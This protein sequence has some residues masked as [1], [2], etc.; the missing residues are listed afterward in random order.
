MNAL[1]KSRD[2]S[3][4]P[5]LRT[6]I[7]RRRREEPHFKISGKRLNHT[8]LTS[9]CVSAAPYNERHN[10]TDFP[11]IPGYSRLFPAIPSYFDPLHKSELLKAKQITNKTDPKTT[12]PKKNLFPPPTDNRP[13]PTDNPKN[14]DKHPFQPRR[15]AMIEKYPPSYFRL[16]QPVEDISFFQSKTPGSQPWPQNVDSRSSQ[17]PCPGVSLQKLSQHQNVDLGTSHQIPQKVPVIPH[18]PLKKC[19]LPTSR[20]RQKVGCGNWDLA[21]GN[22]FVISAW[23]L[24]IPAVY[25]QKAKSSLCIPCALSVF[26]VKRASCPEPQPK[27]SKKPVSSPKFTFQHSAQSP[28]LSRSVVK[29]GQ[30]QNVDC[31]AIPPAPPGTLHLKKPVFAHFRGLW[32]SLSEQKVDSPFARFGHWSFRNSFVLRVWSLVI[33]AQILQLSSFGALAPTPPPDWKIELIAQ[34]PELRHPSVVCSAPDGRVF[35][36]EDPMDISTPRADSTE[37][38]ILCFFPDGHHTVFAEKLHAVFGIQYVEGKVYVLHNPQFSVFTDNNGIGKDRF[39]LIESMNPNPWALEWNDHVPANFKL[40]MDGY[41]YM[42]VGDKGVYGAVGRDGKRVDLP[43][44]GILRLRPDGTGLEVYCT[45]VRNILDVALTDEDEIFTYD[46][47]D[48]HEW[49]GR[50][51]HMV[52]GGFYGYPHDFIPRRPYTLWMMHDFGGGAACGTLAYT[53]DVLPSEYQNNLFLADF[54]KRQV[55]RVRIEREGGTFRVSGSED[56]FANPPNDFRP[57]GI[58]WSADGKGFY[59]CDWNH[60]DTKENVLVGRFWKATYTGQTRGT[61][62]PQW[63]L[64]AAMGKSFHA[65]SDELIEGLSHPSR[66]LRLAAQRALISR[67]AGD[68]AAKLISLRNSG[69]PGPALWHALW[70]L[71]ALD[72]PKAERAALILAHGSDRATRHQSIRMLGEQKSRAAVTPLLASLKDSD[73]SLRFQSATALGRIAD[74]NALPALLQALDEADLYARFAGFTA[75]NRIGRAEP[76]AWHAIIPGLADNNPRIREGTEF[77]IRET[78]DPSLVEALITMAANSTAALP[79]RSSA[80]RC[81]VSLAHR[82][83][84][85]RGEWGAY[86]PALAPAPAKTNVW[87]GTPH[88]FAAFEHALRDP[89]PPLRLLAIEGMRQADDKPSTARTLRAQFKSEHHPDVKAALISALGEFKDAQ[90]TSDL[91]EILNGERENQKIFEAAVE[92]ASRIGGP[93]LENSLLRLSADQNVPG[94]QRTLVIEALGELKSPRTVAVLKPLL[95]NDEHALRLAAQ[96]T[97]AKLGTSEAVAT[98]CSLLTS[99]SREIQR[100]T[101]AA[102]G[103][104]RNREAVPP[105]IKAW[106]TPETREAAISALTEFK[107]I[108]ALDAYIDGLASVDPNLRN[109]CRAALEAMREEA[110]PQIETRV[111]SLS[112]EA[113]KELRFVYRDSQAKA[114]SLFRDAAAPPSQQEYAAYA[115][116]HSGDPVRGQKIF[117]DQTGVACIKCHTVNGQGAPTGPDLTSI[118][119]QFPRADLIEHVLEPSKVVREGYQQWNIETRDGESYSGLIRAESAD[120]LTLI[121][122]DGRPQAIP[123][124]SILSRTASRISLMPEGLQN[125]LT[126]DQFADL[127]AFLESQRGDPSKQGAGP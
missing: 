10:P 9:D 107:D 54:G 100:E 103:R 23:S 101:I 59:I 95:E 63:Y 52:D 81:L 58:T 102:L 31:T 22:S 36:A 65:S 5:R 120:A 91:A 2:Q 108:R 96:R 122:S 32:R 82:P 68:E 56:F 112:T 115:A 66:E 125:A 92:A 124:N 15:S 77:A 119:T 42:A 16:D 123:R 114:P 93:Q 80:L 13:L 106:L 87:E 83:L 53:E 28:F 18:F 34:A 70:A 86:H 57:V 26:V 72:R 64:P 3:T 73:A 4:T 17:S 48:E 78:Y 126:L 71:N 49:M 127:I 50:L 62:K 61:A 99:Q 8:R 55:I 110:L 98:L 51:T 85:W 12:S 40:A 11:R 113:L 84:E 1:D 25:L 39:E 20:P 79:A 74:T 75:L 105:L 44:G 7:G 111:S 97:T 89:E 104:T 90:F 67:K 116:S 38:R 33:L 29:F 41:F 69:K 117:F 94:L 24:V 88:C 37:G 118:G 14:V 21:L 47:T 121:T 19:A 76:R 43:G 35:V 46:N 109:Q 6:E 60:R 30:S 45:G 27:S